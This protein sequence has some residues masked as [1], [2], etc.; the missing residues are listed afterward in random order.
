M[1]GGPL[2]AAGRLPAC[3]SPSITCG[4]LGPLLLDSLPLGVGPKVGARLEAI[5]YG[6]GGRFNQAVASQQR[7]AR[8]ER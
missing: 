3:G 2:E 1:G 5:T 7:A 8:G 4:V 6:G